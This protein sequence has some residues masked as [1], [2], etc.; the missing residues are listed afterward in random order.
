[1][2]AKIGRLSIKNTAFLLCD[3]QEKFRPS[4]RYFPEIIKVAQRMT[5]AA[6]I[7][8]IPVIATEQYPKGLGSTVEEIDTS[9]F[10]ERIFSKT[11][12]S[13]VIPEVEEQLQQLEVEN[14][15]LMGI[16]T[17]VCVLQ[18][19]MDLL[20]RNYS[21]HVLA[22]GVSSRTMVE[23]MFALERIRQI[24][25]FVTTSECTLFMLMG[26]S[27]HPNFKEVQALV[28]TAAPDSGLLSKC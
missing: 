12:F 17:Q 7:L 9:F 23:R 4:I 8:K 3:I 6:N 15:V 21:V 19:T 24:G 27:K 28:K 25:G 14:V 5:A 26:D 1:M 18:T 10:K 11:K 2:A 16:E 22:D 13:M 20:E